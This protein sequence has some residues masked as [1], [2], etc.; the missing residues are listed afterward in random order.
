MR[1]QSSIRSQAILAALYANA[2]AS[3]L[4]PRSTLAF[5]LWVKPGKLQYRANSP[6]LSTSKTVVQFFNC[7]LQD[8]AESKFRFLRSWYAEDRSLSVMC[9]V[10]CAT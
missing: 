10:S 1:G 5:T 8:N 9:P 4:K 3:A 7:S 6:I 2:T